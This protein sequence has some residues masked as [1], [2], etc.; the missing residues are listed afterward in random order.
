MCGRPMM[1]AS[2]TA[3]SNS[4]A[5]RVAQSSHAPLVAARTTEGAFGEAS[6]GPGA[7]GLASVSVLIGVARR[8]TCAAVITRIAISP[9][10]FGS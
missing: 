8:S 3:S 7:H 10:R 5:T 6:V 1:M 9:E 4:K 2:A